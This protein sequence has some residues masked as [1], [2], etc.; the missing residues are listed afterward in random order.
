[1]NRQ[2]LILFSLLIVAIGMT[3]IIFN[4]DNETQEPQQQI[5]KKK[6]INIVLAQTRHDLT[7]GNLLSKKDYT[8]KNISVEESSH[9]VKHALS[10]THSIDGHLL[11]NNILAGSFITQ[12]MLASPNSREF[13]RLNLKNGDVIYKFFITHRDEY[14][15]NTLNPGDSLS[16]QL[17]TLET[18]KRKGIENGIAID[19][20]KMNSRQKQQYS[21]NKIIPDMPILSIKTYSPEELSVKNSKN[22][23]TEK[24]ILGYIEVKIKTQDL[25][26]IHT[27]EKAGEIFLTPISGEHKRINLNDIIPT[28]QTIRELRG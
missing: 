21:L 15:L 1:M 3:G 6:E 23:K 9:L 11:K 19:S 20:N 16:F 14:L 25:E 28:L 27:A 5:D 22:H 17:L 18:N 8:L 10:Q 7:E 13:I 2:F 24:Y 12:E 26:F 4:S